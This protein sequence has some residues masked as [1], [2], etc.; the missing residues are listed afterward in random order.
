MRV[1]RAIDR[2]LEQ[3]ELE[4]DFTERSL[5]SY[6]SVLFRLCDEPP[7]GFGAE[8]QLH[9]LDGQKGTE[10]LREHIARNWGKTSTGRRANVISIHHTFF[11]WSETEGFIEQDPARKIRRPPRRKADVYR[12]P[13]VDQDLGFAATTLYERAPWVLMN[14]VALRASTVVQTRWRHVDLT[15]GRISVRVKGGHTIPLPLS[16]IAL[17]RLRQV[18]RQLDP[19]PNDHVFT[20]EHHRFSGNQRLVYRRDPSRPATTKAL[21]MMVKRICRRA[22]IREFGPH[23]LRHGFATRFLRESGRDIVALK[24]LLGHASVQTTEAYTDELRLEELEE[25]LQKASEARTSVARLGDETEGESAD[26]SNVSHG[27]GWNRTTG[28]P[29]SAETPE[30]QR[31]PD[32]PDRP[33]NAPEGGHKDA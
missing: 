29:R 33:L 23:A 10:R 32:D 1:S 14:D 5:H 20:V 13:A 30:G 31:A 19:D 2:F 6:G 4:R 8:I 12:P 16:P 7:R 11:D 27:P 18:Y 25:A 22:G 28:P 15:R 24:D 17:D 21:W 3:M 9:E 26:L